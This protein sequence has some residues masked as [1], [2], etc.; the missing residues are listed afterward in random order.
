[1]NLTTVVLKSF[2]NENSR[3]EYHTVDKTRLEGNRA[4]C[5]DLDKMHKLAE[6]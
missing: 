5:L 4:R 1:M 6:A 2:M 3:S